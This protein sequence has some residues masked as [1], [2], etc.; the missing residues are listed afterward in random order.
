VAEVEAWLSSGL[1]A[2]IDVLVTGSTERVE[3]HL[4]EVSLVRLGLGFGIDE[5]ATSLMLLEEAARPFVLDADEPR[6]ETLR[7][8]LSLMSAATRETISRFSALYAQAMRREIED[9]ERRTTLMFEAAE[10]AGSSLDLDEV[11]R[12]V[13]RYISTALDVSHCHVYV[14]DTDS[15][16]YMPQKPDELDR[17]PC[18]AVEDRP[19]DPKKDA[20]VEAVVRS[21]QPVFWSTRTSGPPLEVDISTPD[22]LEGTV[23]LPISVG[24][25]L[26]GLAVVFDF[27]PE[28]TFAD[29]QIMLAWGL[30][31]AVASAVENARLH[32]ETRRQLKESRSLQSV[33]E[34][35]LEKLHVDELLDMVCREARA[36]TGADD[37][38]VSLAEDCEATGE[39]RP[40]EASQD[41]GDHTRLSVPLRGDGETIGALRLARRS[42]R[43]TRDDERLAGLFAHQAAIA[44]EGA[45]LRNKLK[46][47]AVLE[48]RQRLAR[49]LHDS[50]TQSLYAVS[51]YAEAAARL[52][53]SGDPAQASAHLRDAR[54][55]SVAALREMRL[56]LFEL[57][58]SVLEKDGLAAALQSRLAAVEERVGLKIDFEVEGSLRPARIV[59]EQLHRIA[60]EALNNALKHACAARITIRLR[61]TASE[62][63]LSISDDGVGFER[64]KERPEGGYGLRGMEERAARIGADLSIESEPG[65]GTTVQVF[66]REPTTEKAPSDGERANERDVNSNSDSR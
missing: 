49:D 12:R 65:K 32:A 22:D 35:L 21:G 31:N 52:L 48:E 3:K 41:P 4:H 61:Q 18:R 24:E 1:D 17:L 60:Q 47:I 25:R 38:R 56:L 20:A 66:V 6:S 14:Y 57:Q 7:T 59:E 63:N 28:R 23:V 10:T 54:A 33:T 16:A 8:T 13:S 46:N 30:C 44:L 64:G 36:L 43:F 34:A 42:G 37:C 15:R 62:V 2:F 9:R 27:D 5:V 51:L 45:R 50:V 40:D 11:L 39:H 58:P 55:T 29:D 19:L 26:Q 53:D